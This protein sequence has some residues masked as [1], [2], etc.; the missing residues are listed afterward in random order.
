M[1]H[2]P[3]YTA[4]EMLLA[5]KNIHHLH[6]S[7]AIPGNSHLSAEADAVRLSGVPSL[8]TA[9][10]AGRDNSTENAHM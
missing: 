10:D 3:K 4:H 2:C 1:L 9:L 8:V 7:P 5:S 6:L